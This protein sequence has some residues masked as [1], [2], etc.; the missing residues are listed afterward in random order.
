MRP[1]AR[2]RD[3]C[4]PQTTAGACDGLRARATLVAACFLIAFAALQT[5]LVMLGMTPVGE[6]QPTA[7]TDEGEPPIRGDI[8]DRN[9][10]LLATSLRAMSLYAD[11]TEVLDIDEVV[12]KL[13]GVL[14]DVDRDTLRQR[15]NRNARFVWIKRNLTPDQVYQVN[16]LGLPG[17]GFRDE[18]VRVYPQGPLAAHLLGGMNQAGNGA[19]GIEAGMNDSLQSGHDLTLSIDSRLQNSL[20]EALLETMAETKAKGVWGISMDPFTGEILAYVSLPDFDPNHYGSA[21]PNQ[22]RDRLNTGVYE[23]GST[24]KM[25]TM[26][27]AMEHKRLSPSSAFDCTAPI[28]IGRFTIRD[29]YPKSRWMSLQEIFRYSS[30]IGASRIADLFEPED[31]QSFLGRLHLL[32]TANIE[33]PGSAAPLRPSFDHWKRIQSMTISFGHGIAVSPVAMISAA[34][35]LVGDGH[36]RQPTVLKRTTPTTAEQIVS[37]RIVKLM[38]DLL[39]DV[40][41]HG[42]AHAARMTGYAVGGKTG[43]AEKNV[44]GQY[45]HHHNL[46]SFFGVLPLEQP[47][48]ATLIM[49]DEGLG[50]EGT[51]GSVAA[52]AFARFAKK[53][54]PILGIAPT[55]GQGNMLA[56]LVPQPGFSPRRTA[57]DIYD[58]VAAIWSTRHP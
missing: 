56:E 10:A 1:R 22:W 3:N 49:V 53:A 34:S 58:S 26:A 27:M 36:W 33:L 45:L 7:Y 18:Y 48:L 37:P 28:R 25:F 52:P 20:R 8:Y 54:V 2:R 5:R 42:T 19:A 55:A 31:Q 12:R 57:G 30:N 24:F 15:L 21:A 14:P 44:N 38:R 41:E 40:A 9:G 4:R 39:Y 16:A 47:R 23:M 51:G 32:D 6:P 17:L 11:P 46:A 35:A 50:G 13:P 43:T 29:P